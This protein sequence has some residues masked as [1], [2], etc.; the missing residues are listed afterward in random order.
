MANYSDSEYAREYRFWL[1]SP[2]WELKNVLAA[3]NM[4]PW[5]NGSKEF[6]RIQAIKD[7]RA[8]RRKRRG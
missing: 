1:R 8:E 3:L 7:I 4:L 2:D 5:A 6:A